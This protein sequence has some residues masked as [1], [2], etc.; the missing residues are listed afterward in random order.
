M[1]NRI[2]LLF[3]TLLCLWLGLIVKGLFLQVLPNKKLAHKQKKQFEKIVTLKPRR[4]VITDTNGK[5]LAVSIA[6]F[7]LFAD[8]KLVK[9]PQVAARKLSKYLNIN[10]KSLHKKLLDKKKRFIWLKRQLSKK[11]KTVINNWKI[12]GLGFIDE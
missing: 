6:S 4:G 10:Y 1:K 8:P 9:N 3:F 5:E 2:L 12:S 11:Q 7:S